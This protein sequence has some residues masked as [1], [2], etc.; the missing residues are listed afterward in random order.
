MKTE[1]LRQPNVGAAALARRL[2]L[3]VLTGG[4]L[5]PTDY[6]VLGETLNNLGFKGKSPLAQDHPLKGPEAVSI[7]DYYVSL[8]E[9]LEYQKAL[10][11]DPQIQAILRD[12]PIP[13]GKY[14]IRKTTLKGIGAEPGDTVYRLD[15]NEIY[16]S[17][18]TLDEIET[19]H[20][21]GF[22]IAKKGVHNGH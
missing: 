17:P 7:M 22:G 16:G 9:N 5:R 13:E 18:I 20:R 1:S 15:K 21:E 11:E 19:D 8:I 4:T 3:H 2:Y 6:R 10:M 14:E 12:K